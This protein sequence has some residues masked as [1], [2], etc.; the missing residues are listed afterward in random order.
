MA[1][2]LLEAYHPKEKAG[3]IRELLKDSPVLDIWEDRLS[4]GR[5]VTR[6]LLRTEHT[7][8]VIEA[9]E[10]RFS[11]VENFRV[12]MLSVEAT[13]PRPEETEE[14]KA[15]KAEK[16]RK[17]TERI[18]VEELY[19][20]LVA[21]CRCYRDFVVMVTLASFVAA[22]GLI[23]N[24]PAV[25]IGSMV[26]APLLNPN[27]ALSLATTLADMPLARKALLANLMGIAIALG[28]GV[29]MGLFLDVDPRVQQIVVR[30][31]V[32]HYYIALALATGVAGSYSLATGVAEAL[33]G[34]MV[35]VALLPPL[36]TSGLLFGAGQWIDAVGAMLLFL[37]NITSI[38]LSGI[39]TFA[40][41][42]IRPRRW[43]EAKKAKRAVKKAAVLWVLMLAVLAVLIIFEQ[44]IKTTL[45]P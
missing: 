8:A 23:K 15:E 22:L 35:A 1:L 13:L 33:V 24:D 4:G 11:P 18:N 43:W 26:I 44:Q 2:R 32:R 25:V 19:Q 29:L 31:D 9:L 6:L 39:L 40:L 42:G 38:N 45:T 30:S 5:A 41:Q 14:E 17:K 36:V 37:V 7:E 27:M 16:A 34:V 12:V 10:K 21:G 28:I 20:K 3:D